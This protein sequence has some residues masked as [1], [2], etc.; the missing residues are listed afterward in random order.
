MNIQLSCG[1]I[2]ALQN[3]HVFSGGLEQRSLKRARKSLPRKSGHLSECYN[4]KGGI[5]G[6]AATKQRC[7]GEL[8]HRFLEG[9]V[10]LEHKAHAGGTCKRYN[11]DA[12]RAHHEG[13]T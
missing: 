5:P 13:C 9:S 1:V 12:Y 10:Q 4:E 7:E 11:Q 3:V 2:N 8:L 6:K